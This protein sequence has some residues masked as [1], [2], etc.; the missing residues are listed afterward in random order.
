MDRRHFLKLTG[1]AVAAT[2]VEAMPAAAAPR[3]D[4]V[5]SEPTHSHD[6]A[7]LPRVT[8][9]RRL[10]VS[11]PGTY[12]IYG[13]IRL[14][15]SSVEISGITTTQRISWS[16]VDGAERPLAS[17]TSFERYDRAGLTP[18]IS[19]LGGRLA[20]LTMVPVDLE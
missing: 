15:D 8:D 16:G 11:E 9:N 5:L 6:L 19:V 4:G 13:Q 3:P 1:L 17:F 12:Q 20:A 14:E 18:P 7:S 10:S 2:A